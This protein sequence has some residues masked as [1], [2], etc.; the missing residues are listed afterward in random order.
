[1]AERH[2]LTL[3]PAALIEAGYHDAPNYRAIYE[4]ARSARI[5]A[6]LTKAGKWT[7][8]PADLP[9]I[10]EALGLSEAYAA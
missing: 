8:D 6:K 3:A 10:A 1:M 2:P 9:V 4:A 5:P 7:F